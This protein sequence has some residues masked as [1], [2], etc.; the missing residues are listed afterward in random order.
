M[1][2]HAFQQANMQGVNGMPMGMQLNQLNPQQLHQLRQ[3]GRLGPVS[4]TLHARL[5]ID[6]R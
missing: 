6:L 3:S 2:Q 5:S 1:A 4:L